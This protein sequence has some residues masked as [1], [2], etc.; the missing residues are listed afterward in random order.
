MS[1][2][3]DTT[4]PEGPGKPIRFTVPE[5][6]APP[7]SVLD[8]TEQ[9]PKTAGSTVTAVVATLSGP[10]T[11]TFTEAYPELVMSRAM[12]A[13]LVKLRKKRKIG[14][15]PIAKAIGM[16]QAGISQIENLKRNV[17]LESVMI[18]AQAIG[19]KITIALDDSPPE[20]KTQAVE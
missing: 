20:R 16:T 18:Y 7:F 13:E 14:Q 12:M 15:A 9:V 5:P 2:L 17:S 1:L 8:T 10:E 11:L 4:T 6:L 3:K 19:A